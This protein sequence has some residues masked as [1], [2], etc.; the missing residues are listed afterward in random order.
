MA[1]VYVKRF[2]GED[3]AGLGVDEARAKVAEAEVMRNLEV[4]VI[5][6]AITLAFKRR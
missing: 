6:E 2:L 3:I 5:A 1:R 4:G